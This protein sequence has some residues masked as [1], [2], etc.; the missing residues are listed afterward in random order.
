MSRY[1]AFLRGINLGNR[2]VKM[3]RLREHFREMGLENVASFIASGNVIFD[4]PGGDGR[5]LEGRIET[6][7]EKE[8]GFFTET[9]V[10][11]MERL[12]V[13][14]T[15]PDLEGARQEGFTP[16][17]IFLRGEA[18]E[19]L[20]RALEPFEGPDDRFWIQ[21]GEVVWLR[22]GGVTDAPFELRKLEAALG[23][24]STRRKLNTVER[25]AEKFGA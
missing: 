7:L 5:A 3:G 21:G 6:H 14:A 16:Y 4:D 23:V 25:I 11:P 22:R 8:L 24:E 12:K 15:L 17:V 10:R 1:V 13:I 9:F 19:D 18:E 20:A 2:R